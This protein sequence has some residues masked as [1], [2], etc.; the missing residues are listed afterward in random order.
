MQ[1]PVLTLILAWL[2]IAPAV[3]DEPPQVIFGLYSLASTN[4]FTESDA[5][6]LLHLYRNAI[7]LVLRRIQ[8]V[9]ERGRVWRG[10]HLRIGSRQTVLGEHCARQGKR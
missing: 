8:R 5:N 6:A 9:Q 10:W 1:K 7:A 2:A 3:A 4:T